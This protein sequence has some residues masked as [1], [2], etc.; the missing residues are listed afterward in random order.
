[1]KVDLV[2]QEDIVRIE[3]KKIEDLMPA[4]YNPRKI[5][6]RQYDNLMHSIEKF[7][8]IEPI[9]WNEETGHVVGGHQRLKVLTDLGYKEVICVVI[10]IP[11]SEEKILNVTLNNVNGTFEQDNLFGIL[12]EASESDL[13]L[14]GF[15]DLELLRYKAK[16]E[17]RYYADL[18]ERTYNAYNLNE[19]DE[20]R[21]N[22]KWQMPKIKACHYIPDSLIPFDYVLRTPN[23]PQGCGVHYF[24]DDYQFERVWSRPYEN[25]ERLKKFSCTLTPQFSMYTDMPLPMK[26]WNCYRS[27]I[28]GQMM[29]DYGLTVIPTLSW[30]EDDTL[31][32]S[33]D[34]IESGGVVAASTIGAIRDKEWRDGWKKGMQVA[35]EKLTP[36]CVLLYGYKTDIDFD[37]GDTKVKIFKLHIMERSLVK[38]VF[39]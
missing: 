34:G 14:T 3:S 1:M 36:E 32:W 7:G 35:L 37:F 28:I 27:K 33:F 39:K 23:P 11:E 24:V 16:K 2:Q 22:G 29:Q 15:R 31:D 10:S 30:A 5:T 17:T 25:F 20:N 38:G 12:G 9:I 8:Y 21:V 18:R 6:K 4:S 13:K 19:Y 26:M